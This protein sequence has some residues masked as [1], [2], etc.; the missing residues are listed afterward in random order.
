[1][2]VVQQRRI[3]LVVASFEQRRTTL[4]CTVACQKFQNIIHKYIMIFFTVSPIS[5][6]LGLS[7]LDPLLLIFLDLIPSCIVIG[8]GLSLRL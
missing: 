1:M 3:R 5:K 7:C 4:L 8:P 6:S 2:S